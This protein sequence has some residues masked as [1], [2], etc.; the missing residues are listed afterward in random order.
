MADQEWIKNLANANLTNGSETLEP[1]DEES[2]R[3]LL[4][5]RIE[6]TIDNLFVEM[7]EATQVF[8]FF[9]SKEQEIKLY[10]LAANKDQHASG[11]TVLLGK[12][13]VRFV[14]QNGQLISKLAHFSGYEEKNINVRVFKPFVDRFG[15]LMLKMNDIQLMDA[16]MIIKQVLEDVV[17]AFRQNSF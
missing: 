4:T 7:T 1:Q 17:T 13:H 15:S 5:E 6:S 11:F 16:S 14:Y 8:N 12:Y 9:V 10:R 2:V 3:A